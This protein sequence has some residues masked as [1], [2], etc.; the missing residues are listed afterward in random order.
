L[1]EPITALGEYMCKVGVDLESE[2][3]REGVAPLTRLL[4]G[5][6]ISKQ[7]RAERCERGEGR[8]ILSLHIGA[9]EQEASWTPFV[10]G[11]AERPLKKVKLA[12]SD[13][14]RGLQKAIATVFSGAAW[15]RCCVHFMRDVLGHVPK[16]DKSIVA[17][18]IRSLFA[19]PNHEAARQPLQQVI[20]AMETRW[21]KAAE[22]LE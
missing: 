21:P 20:R 17:A 12:T 11:L 16:R 10:R 18:A 9:S 7:I 8:E 4:T 2:F 15:Q 1:T 13:A 3:L 22:L 5:L 14:Q 6:S 19:Q